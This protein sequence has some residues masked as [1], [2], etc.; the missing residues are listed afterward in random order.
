MASQAAYRGNQR[1]CRGKRA[2]QRRRRQARTFV[3][4]ARQFLTPE[5][6]KQAGRARRSKRCSSRWGVQP[7]VFVLLTMTWC[8]GDSTSERFETARAYYV[9]CHASRKRPGKTH[10]GFQAALSKLPM[11]VLRGIGTAIRRQLLAQLGERLVTGGWRVFGCDGSRIECPR[12]VELERR[13]GKA[14]KEGAAPTAWLTAVVHLRSG[15][16]WAWRVG[17]G[18][19]ALPFLDGVRAR[20][21]WAAQLDAPAER[22]SAAAGER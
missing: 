2:R 3:Q 4:C 18:T 1:A 12:S 16:L 19:A 14:G 21:S 17:K 5:V 20:G 22:A 7:L 10:Q 15:L 6:F 8:M 11:G 9:A 13:L